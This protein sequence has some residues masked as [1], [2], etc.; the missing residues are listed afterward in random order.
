MHVAPWHRSHVDSSL[1]LSCIGPSF[2]SSQRLS[3]HLSAMADGLVADTHGRALRLIAEVQG[4]HFQGLEQAARVL[5]RRG[6]CTSRLCKQLRL[7]GHAFQLTRH[8]TAVSAE[9][10]L[11]NLAAELQATANENF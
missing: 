7:I 10:F 3:V 5:G 2:V 1:Q 8:I 11:G 9:R 6:A 4:E